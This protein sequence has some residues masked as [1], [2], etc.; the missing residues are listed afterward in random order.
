MRQ[1]LME[2]TDLIAV[3]HSKVAQALAMQRY[4]LSKVENLGK[5]M[6]CE[7]LAMPVGVK[8]Y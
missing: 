2:I 6:K 1:E 7:Y 4:L 3:S 5:S 8:N